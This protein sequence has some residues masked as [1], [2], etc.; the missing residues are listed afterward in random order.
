MSYQRGSVWRKWDLHVHTPASV[1]HNYSCGEAEDVW[2]KFISELEGLPE[3]IKVLGI[4]DYIFIEGYRKVLEY[5]QAGRLA[6]IDLILPV[7]ELRLNKFGGTK[8]KLSRVNY[9]VIFS[10]EISPDVIQNQFLHALTSNYKLDPSCGESYWQGVITRDSLEEL[11]R[12]IKATVPQEQLNHYGS[13]FIEGFNNLNLE[14]SHVKE[15]LSRNY[16]KGKYLTAVGKTEWA[17]IKWNDHSIADKKT[18]INTSDFVFIAS[19]DIRHFENA[20]SSLIK[21]KVNSRLLD[22]SD[23]HYFSDSVE[24][25]RLGNCLTWLKCDPTFEGLKQIR[26]EFEDRVFIGDIPA[27]LDK[28]QKNPTKYIKSISVR[29]TEGS[30]HDGWFNSTIPLN[31]DLIAVIGN[32]G[33]GKS[34][35]ADIMGLLGNTKNHKEFSFLVKNKFRSGSLANGFLGEIE[36]ES[37]NKETKFLSEDPQAHETEK[38]KYL[39]QQ[40]IEKICNLDND[41]F[42]SELKQVIFSHVIETER[43]Q[44]QSLDE[45]IE[46]RTGRFKDNINLLKEELKHINKAIFD[47]EKLFTS[48]YKKK[49]QEKIEYKKKEIAVQQGLKPV[50]VVE[51]ETDPQIQKKLEELHGELE[52]VYKN[53]DD[54]EGFKGKVNR[55]LSSIE[56]VEGH[57]ENFKKQYQL[58]I[59]NCEKELDGIG[60]NIKEMMV[61][62]TNLEALEKL[63]RELIE[64]KRQLDAKLQQQS[65]HSLFKTKETIEGEIRKLQVQLDEPQRKYQLYQKELLE[66]QM[67][68]ND[69]QKELKGLEERRDSINGQVAAELKQFKAERVEKVQEIHENI[70]KIKSIYEELYK[71]VQEFISKHELADSNFQLK[72][73][74]SLQLK[75][76]VDKCLS[77]INQG[78]KGAFQGKEEGRNILQEIVETHD[79][80]NTESTLDFITTVISKL[81]NKDENE[82]ETY[83]VALQLTKHATM[84]EF[85][86]YLFSLSYLHPVYML[87]LGEKE[88]NTLSPGEKGTLLL[89]FYLLVD[90]DDIPLIIDQPEENLD[91]QTVYKLL[92]PSIKEAKNRRQIIIVTHNPNLAVVCDAEQIIHASIDKVNNNNISYE[93]GSIESPII[94]KKLIDILE[95]TTPAFKNRESKYYMKD[96]H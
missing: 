79:F 94:N 95:G 64:Q 1:V 35:L 31:H 34:A 14:L 65:D 13:D 3:D 30:A 41:K 49:F 10:N 39:P 63:K 22:C 23:A 28:V 18:I 59:A 62:Q 29:K 87:K 15:V 16:F 20:K 52:N 4:N 19:P 77:Y 7:I 73:E 85:Y 5:K 96:V 36:W 51:V 25:D 44:Q 45:L 9:H 93:V 42:E 6:N 66:W 32:K 60:L 81:C 54:S 50:E 89:I 47:L 53:I 78:V 57:I 33:N 58:F 8:S 84:E 26:N 43:L 12:K 38:V 92:V 17:D 46:L 69:L 86:D 2:E 82:P 67:K 91:N 55:D 83:N 24:K 40:F 61:V 27:K 80:N 68:S 90:N 70:I 88:L 21:E 75:N 76:F 11:G 71:P 72:F 48:D 56:R 37:G 74:V